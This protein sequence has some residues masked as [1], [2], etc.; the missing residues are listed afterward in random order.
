MG[1]NLIRDRLAVK[2]SIEVTDAPERE[3]ATAHSTHWLHD[4]SRGFRENFERFG[5]IYAHRLIDN[6]L[7]EIDRLIEL[8]RSLGQNPD[9]V[10]FHEGNGHV[11]ERWDAIPISTRPVETLIREIETKG[12]WILL[13]H[14]NVLPGYQAI[15]EE[16]ISDIQVLSGRDLAPTMK[17]K[18]AIIFLNSPHRTTTYHI[19]HQSSLLLQLRGTKTISIFDPKDRENLPEIE[20]ERFWAGDDNAAIYKPQYQNRASVFEL[21]PG[22]GVHIPL[23]A[24]HWVQNGPE[25]SV[26]LNVNFDYH[27]RLVGDIYRANYWLRKAGLR[28]RPPHTSIQGDK[29]KTSAYEFARSLRALIARR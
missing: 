4:D 1:R 24:P 6:P 9:N 11:D 29:L 5:F 27:D 2:P 19:D 16:L 3:S 18:K 25:V 28:P 20:L 26:S 22:M 8:S 13:K 17:S 10:V 12:A 14:V 23:N 15:L 7:F 21:K